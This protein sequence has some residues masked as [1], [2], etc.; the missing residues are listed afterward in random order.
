M[1]SQSTSEQTALPLFHEK[2]CT[3]C[4]ISKPLSEFYSDKRHSDGTRSRCISCTSSDVQ[5]THNDVKRE[6]HRKYRREW[7]I[8]NPEKNKEYVKRRNA[9]TSQNRYQAALGQKPECCEICGKYIPPKNNRRQM[10]V[11]HDHDTGAIRGLL[12]PQCNSLLGLSLDSQTRLQ[13]AIDYLNRY[14]KKDT[15]MQK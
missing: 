4:K 14:N 3:K 2:P 10:F 15:L 1:R 8:K 7:I 12:C 9:K 5:G 11:D 6:Y 13:Q